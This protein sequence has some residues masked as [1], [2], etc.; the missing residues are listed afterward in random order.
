MINARKV[1]TRETPTIFMI[2]MAN[3]LPSIETKILILFFGRGHQQWKQLGT[4]Y[5]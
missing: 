2:S 5:R 3:S 1:A 4:E